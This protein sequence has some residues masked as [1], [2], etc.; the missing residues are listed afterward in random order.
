MLGRRRPVT[1]IV[2]NAL[3][4]RFGD[5]PIV[6]EEGVSGFELAHRRAKRIGYIRTVGQ[7]LFIQTIARWLRISSRARIAEIERQYALDTTPVTRDVHY[8]RSINEGTVIDLLQAIR[9]EIVV[10]FGT[11]IIGRS[12]LDAVPARFINM[13][14][15][16]TPGFRGSHGAYWALA[17]GH[18]ELAGVT[19]HWVDSGIDTGGIV[20]QARIEIGPRDNFITYSYLQLAAGLPLLLQAV[21]EALCGEV[22][23]ESLPG[24]LAA[25]SH[26]YHHPTI[27]SYLSSC[28]RGIR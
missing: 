26:L 7:I 25:G 13:H 10:V 5:F 1:D 27:W 9:P 19:I 23:E 12:V 15:G 21:E 6:Y 17:T 28:L 20:K 11:R 4:A 24:H 22:R 16:I 18:P 14:A 3:R 8:V 2:A